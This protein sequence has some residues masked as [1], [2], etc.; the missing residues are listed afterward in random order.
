MKKRFAFLSLGLLT[1]CATLTGESEQSITVSTKPA[2]AHCA[3]SNRQGTWHIASTPGSARVARSYSPL[4]I[5][6]DHKTAGNGAATIEPVTSARAYPNALLLGLP[7]FIDA[8]TGAG[9][10]Y[11]TGPVT[12]ALK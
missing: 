3:L 8:G 10:E 11:D 5:T 9:Y 4:V 12:I 2:G 6:C 7:A 1:A